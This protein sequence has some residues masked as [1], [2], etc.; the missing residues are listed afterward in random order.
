MTKSKYLKV[1]LLLTKRIKYFSN[2]KKVDDS[3]IKISVNC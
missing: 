2:V 3:E 1:K